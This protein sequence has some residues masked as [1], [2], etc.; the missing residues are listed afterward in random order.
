MGK[1][2]LIVS[3]NYYILKSLDSIIKK[4][5]AKALYKYAISPFSDLKVFTGLG[6]VTV[7]DLRDETAVSDIIINYDLVISAHC[8]QLFPPNLVNSVRCI[9]VHPGYNPINRGWYPQVFAILDNVPIGATIHEMDEELDHG[10]IIAREMVPKFS[11]DTSLTLY[12]R[13]VDKELE[14][15]GKYFNKIISGEY[16]TLTPTEEGRLFLKKDFNKLLQL[17]LEQTSTVE[18]VINTLRA[19]THGEYKN[20]Y[21]I[22]KHTGRKVYVSIQLSLDNE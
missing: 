19:L 16:N 1:S 11:W 3:D 4:S 18:N 9:N 5:Q 6:D 20:A 21:F 2:V 13:V 15:L 7:V 12:N 22:D 8:K 10:A 14:L 17:D